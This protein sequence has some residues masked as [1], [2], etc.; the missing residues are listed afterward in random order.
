MQS[1]HRTTNEL[2]VETPTIWGLS[3]EQLHDCYWAALGICAVRPGNPEQLP[4]DATL[5]LLIDPHMLVLFDAARVISAFDHYRMILMRISQAETE[6]YREHVLAGDDGNFLGCQRIYRTT[7][8]NTARVVITFSRELAEQWQ[9]MGE[10]HRRWRRLRTLVRSGLRGVARADGRFYDVDSDEELSQFTS[11]LLTRWQ[12]PDAS[13]PKVRRVAS[14]VFAHES[15]SIDAT[16]AVVGAAWLGAGRTLAAG[17]TVLG[18]AILWDDPLT[19]VAPIQINFSAARFS[20]RFHDYPAAIPQNALQH[21]KYGFKRLFAI[22]KRAFDIVVSLIGLMVTLP[23][24]PLVMF[25][26]WW[27]DGR[28]FFFVHHRETVGGREF[29]C[30]K[31]RSMRKNADIVKLD[32]RK[33]NLADGPQFYMPGDPRITNVGR[34]IRRMNL[35]EMPQLVNVLLGD[36]SLIGPR[37]SPHDENQCCPTW[38]EARLSVRP[39]ITGLWQVMRTREEGLDFQE[40]IRYDLEYVENANWSM[41]IRILLKTAGIL[42]KS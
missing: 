39:G 1:T 10:S 20:D 9:A 34:R 15:A 25:A 4:A 18:P 31:F 14:D 38:R 19:P 8:Q 29:P 7:H 33:K 17:A 21:H 30:I 37:P 27:E 26:I 28:P 5:F 13:V 36:M 32:L 6:G 2:S 12:R 40:W 11:D 42:V 24:Y 41:D 22:T 3:P 35:D 23:L 16:C